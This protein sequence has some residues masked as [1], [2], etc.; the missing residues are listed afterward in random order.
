MNGSNPTFDDLGVR[1]RTPA[2]IRVD[3]LIRQLLR[4]GD[5]RDPREVAEGLKRLFPKDAGLLASEAEGFAVVPSRMRAMPRAAESMAT[6]AELNQAVADIDRD[7]VALTTDH[8]LKGISAELLGWGQAIR[9]IV[10]DGASA[11]RLALD[12]RARDR[13]FGARRQLCD[14]SRL[15]RLIGALT[16]TMN[17]PYRR[18]AQSL[19]EVAGLL[20]VLAGEALAGAGLGGGRFLLSVPASELQARRDAVLLALRTLSGTTEQAYGNDQWPWGLHGLREMLRQIEA[21][22]HLDL[23][24]LL[25]EP[26]IGRLMD[27]LIERASQ[28]NVLGLRALGATA[29]VAVQRLHRLL[30]LIDDRVQPESPAVTT[31]LK[32]IQLFLDAFRSSRSGYRLLFV[33]RA[34]I[35]FYGLAGIG[36]PDAATHRLIELVV[37]R[38]RLAELLDCYLGCECCSD[39][40]ICQILL[41]KILYDTDRAIDLYTLG[42]DPDGAGEPE[43]RA[44]AFA[45]LIIQ[46]LNDNPQEGNQGCLAGACFPRLGELVDSLGLIR[47]RLAFEKLTA[48]GSVVPGDAD[49]QAHRDLMTGELCLQRQADRRLE[50]VIATLSAGC[51]PGETVLT[52]IE[53][54][55]D[56]AIAR[57][58]AAHGECPEV[59][60]TVPHTLESSFDSLNDF[61]ERARSLGLI[62]RRGR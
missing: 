42:S 22:G 5:P 28:H 16:Q 51:V 57:I 12:P 59:E 55:I 36:G 50:A 27:E 47:D 29:D 46:F 48:S 54:L 30:H 26:V 61:S 56:R 52:A 39:D 9:S 53:T 23:R 43:W 15:A 58:D 60:I 21:S 31:F 38:G 20:L 24:A 32:A 25:E 34:P 17:Q 13:L 19:D 40:I 41:D 8:R 62:N 11:A 3:N 4:I 2:A 35:A 1:D 14:Y 49:A 7:L 10:A 18:L 6:G 44:A 37:Q 33:A 45:A